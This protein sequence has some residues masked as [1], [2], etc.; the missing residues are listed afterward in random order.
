MRGILCFLG[1]HWAT[2]GQGF[3]SLIRCPNCGHIKRH[4]QYPLEM[5]CVVTDDGPKKFIWTSW[6]A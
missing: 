4:D 1:V 3:I 2:V 5:D 6:I